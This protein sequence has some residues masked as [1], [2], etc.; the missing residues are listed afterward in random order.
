MP[1]R[2]GAHVKGPKSAD[3]KALLAQ[4]GL[5]TVALKFH[6]N[7]QVVANAESRS[8][9]CRLSEKPRQK[10]LIRRFMEGI[11]TLAALHRLPVINSSIASASSGM[12]TIKSMFVPS[13]TTTSFSRRTARPSAGM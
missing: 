1:A 6:A 12:C 8:G 4:E 9:Q 13:P 11:L 2:E 3:K 5:F 7:I 10:F